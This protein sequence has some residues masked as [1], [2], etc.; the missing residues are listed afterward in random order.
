MKDKKLLRALKGE[1]FDKPPFCDISSPPH[2]DHAFYRENFSDELG[3]TI[4]I[5]LDNCMVDNGCLLMHG[6]FEMAGL[7]ECN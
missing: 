1:N 6:P 7:W 5:A 2:Q 4:W 3:I